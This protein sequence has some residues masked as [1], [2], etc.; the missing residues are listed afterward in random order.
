MSPILIFAELVS[1]LF[2]GQVTGQWTATPFNPPALPLAVRTPYLSAWLE[3]SKGA[4]SP[5]GVYP[6]YRDQ[7][8]CDLIFFPSMLLY[9]VLDHETRTSSSYCPLS[10]EREVEEIARL[11]DSPEQY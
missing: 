11:C 6:Q 8:V 7:S 2:L 3:Q 10:K 4:P 1:I 5:N 9:K